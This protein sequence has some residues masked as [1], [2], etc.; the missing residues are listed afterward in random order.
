M[1]FISVLCLTLLSLPLTSALADSAPLTVFPQEIQLKGKHSY[2]H[3]VIDQAE[4]EFVT[5]RTREATIESLTPEICRVEENIIFPVDNGTGKIRV[6]L[7]DQTQEL[8][9]TVT[10]AGVVQQIDFNR[11]I[12]P[13]LTRYG[14]NSGPCHGKARGQNGFQ[15]SLLGFDAEF[16]YNA[17]TKETRGRRLF[18]PAP[19]QSLILQK[20][21]AVIPH[22]GGKKLEPGSLEYNLLARWIASGTPEKQPDTPT[23]EKVTV[24]PS[25][26]IMQNEKEQQLIVTAHYSDG[27]QKDVTRLTQYQS[28]EAAIAD[29]DE[30]G[31]ITSGTVTG[32]AA[33]MARYHNVIAICNV[34]VPLPGDVDENIYDQLPEQN[35]IDGLVW[36]NLKELKLLPSEQAP[37][38]TF[39]RRAYLDVIG[40]APTAAETRAFLTDSSSDKRILLIDHLLEQPEYA[41]FWSSKWADLLRPNPYRVGIKAVLNYDNFIRES[42]R[43]NK[44]YDQFVRELVTAQ[45]STFRN[46]AVTLFRDRRT[47]DEVTTMVGQLFLGIRLDCAR[48]HHHP[49]EIWGQDDFYSFAAYFARVKYKGTGLSPPISGSEEMIYNG[50]SGEVKH[51]LTNEVLPPRPLFGEAPE[52]TEDLDRRES[53]AIWMTAKENPF[54]SQ[55]M[56]N[57]VWADLMGRGMVEPVDDLRGTNPAV[58]Q[59]LLTALGEDFAA[60]DF[61]IKQLIRRICTSYV[62][63][64]SSNPVE[65]NT[66]DTR[67]YSRYYRQ[68]LRAEVLLDSIIQITGDKQS[69]QA[70]PAG[71]SAKELWTTRI[72]SLFLDAFGRPDP[73]QDPPCERTTDTTIVQALHLM[74]SE[75][76]YK[77]VTSDKGYAATLVASDKTNE[78]IIEELYLS[79]YNRFPDAEEREVAISIYNEEGAD[80]KMV[81][82]DLMWAM[83]NTPEFVFKD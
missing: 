10:N 35:F 12:M 45:G 40:R 71:V 37:D 27:T 55:V 22:G 30:T 50:P 59:E 6:S 36:K 42:F 11:D 60:H 34:S 18:P 2:Q 14:C 52:I 8:S 9:V 77:K 83:L 69:F 58:N 13:L 49:F 68:R 38:H 79:V 78:Q 44:P 23:L 63:G 5:D 46:G 61:N 57:R 74:N 41:E 81:T 75:E 1:K 48:C 39:L 56:A 76:L 82:E 66:V 32:K 19:E 3:M 7:G 80:R 17:L 67:N 72:N 65:R 31:L 70:M 47:P 29:I 33:V 4:G 16:D 21:S 26:R 15:L 64:L 53:L 62:Y 20:T 24:Y 25:A 43:E 73:N 54:F 51:P 28:N